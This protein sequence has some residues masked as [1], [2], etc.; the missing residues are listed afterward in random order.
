MNIYYF[1]TLDQNFNN[2]SEV[3]NKS[4]QLYFRSETNKN[5]DIYLTLKWQVPL[6][7]LKV[8]QFISLQ[9]KLASMSMFLCTNDVNHTVNIPI[10]TV[11][12]HD[13]YKKYSY[14]VNT[15]GTKCIGV[16]YTSVFYSDCL[17]FQSSNGSHSRLKT[18][19]YILF[20]MYLVH[21]K[22]LQYFRHHSPAY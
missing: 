12:I 22:L 16:N 8:G 17:S 6:S 18:K 7:N 10:K 5:F 19:K 4:I 9:E 1:F 15:R 11:W 3:D 20:N 13:N 14:Y 2:V 21:G